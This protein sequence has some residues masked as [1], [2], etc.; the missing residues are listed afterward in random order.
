MCSVTG[1]ATV[2]LPFPPAWRGFRSPI[3]EEVE[4]WKRFIRL[5]KSLARDKRMAYTVTFDHVYLEGNGGMTAT[6][7]YGKIAQ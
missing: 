5:C 4:N 1:R 7:R 3:W 2:N 6:I